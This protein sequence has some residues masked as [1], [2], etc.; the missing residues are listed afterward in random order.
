M[1][2]AESTALRRSIRAFLPKPVEQEKH[3]TLFAA[4]QR[5]PSWALSQPWKIFVSTGN[6]L[7]RTH[8]GYHEN[9][10]IFFICVKR[11]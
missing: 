6:T 3:M 5:I 8:K 2:V 9:F 10:Q 1:K 11:T 7:L 4:V